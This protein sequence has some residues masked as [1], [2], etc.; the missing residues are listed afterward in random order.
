MCL[1]HKTHDEILQRDRLWTIVFLGV[2]A[3]DFFCLAGD[4]GDHVK[5]DPTGHEIKKL[6][7]MQ[8]DGNERSRMAAVS[9]SHCSRERGV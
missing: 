7:I 4:I 8:R 5:V 6:G 1:I 2:Y 9:E 3:E